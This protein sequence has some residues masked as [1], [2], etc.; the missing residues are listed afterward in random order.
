MTLE[1]ILD[2]EYELKRFEKR[3]KIAKTKIAEDCYALRGCKETASLKR[4]AM[5]LKFELTKITR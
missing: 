4:S 2:V 5:D 3:L 1:D